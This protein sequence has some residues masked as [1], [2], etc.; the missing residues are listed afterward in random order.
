M[1]IGMVIT[2]IALAALAAVTFAV[3]V[4]WRT[5][6]AVESSYMAGSQI[7]ARFGQ[8]FRAAAKLGASHAGTLTSSGT[9]A[10]MFFWK[11]DVESVTYPNGDGKIEFNEIGLIAYDQ[12]SEEVRLYSVS[13]WDSWT[14]AAQAAANVLASSLYINTAAN[15]TDF[16]TACNGYKVLL[17]NCTG[18]VIKSYTSDTPTVEYVVN[19]RRPDGSVGTYYSTLT[20]RAS[21]TSSN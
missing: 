2:S 8:Y 12:A 16:K 21:Q 9:A 6:E 11:G 5:A 1:L 20:L 10:A 7:N 14:P 19:I 18:M 15:M 4:N 17:K 13:D 3:G